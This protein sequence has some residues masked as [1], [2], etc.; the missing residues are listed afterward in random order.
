MPMRSDF[1]PSAVAGESH[2]V[3]PITAL[4]LR[5]TTNLLVVALFALLATSTLERFV[6]SGSF[7]GF[8]LLTVNTLAL[9]LFLTR[10]PAKSETTSPKLWALALLGTALPLLLRATRGGESLAIGSEIQLFG[11]AMLTASLLSIR[12]SFAIVPGNRCIQDGGLYRCVRHPLYVSELL[13]FLGVVIASP[14]PFN[15]AIWIFECVVQLAR[16]LAEER[17]L[18]ADP[19]Y[20]AYC[21]RVRYRLIPWVV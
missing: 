6:A 2:L 17:F 16:A 1:V 11:L 8:G 3:S 18:S 15:V 21:A 14:T 12:R 7:K 10:R 20:G 13:F 5:S 19:L 4:V 9:I